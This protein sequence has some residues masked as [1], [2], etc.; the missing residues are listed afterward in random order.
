MTL[1]QKSRRRGAWLEW[2]RRSRRPWGIK[3]DRF[4]RAHLL[5]GPERRVACAALDRARKDRDVRLL[6]EGIDRVEAIL[7]E[8]LAPKAVWD[9]SHPIAVVPGA[10]TDKRRSANGRVMAAAP[11]L[12]IAARLAHRLISKNHRA[13]T[14]RERLVARA[15]EL[16]LAKAS[17]T[18]V[19]RWTVVDDRADLH[20]WRGDREHWR[21]GERPY[22]CKECNQP[23]GYA[24]DGSCAWTE[25]EAARCQAMW[26]TLR[27]V[28]EEQPLRLVVSPK[29]RAPR[30]K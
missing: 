25:R 21:K 4:G 15:L 12:V 7:A 14:A 26:P 1:Q 5:V 10:S 18:D 30:K 29:R 22:R 11:E 20:L 27:L 19:T 17:G 2:G 24:H 3:H 16:A 13:S 23:V 9:D 8:P 6:R 28:R